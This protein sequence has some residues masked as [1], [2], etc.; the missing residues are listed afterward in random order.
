MKP[1]ILI[2]VGSLVFAVGG[3]LALGPVMNFVASAQGGNS[4]GRVAEVEPNDVF[5]QATALSSP[6]PI[7]RL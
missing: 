3:A 2:L 6:Q 4:E 1:R 7:W 5:T